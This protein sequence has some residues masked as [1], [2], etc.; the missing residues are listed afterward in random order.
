[1]AR[2][3]I[4]VSAIAEVTI[5]IVRDGKMLYQP[6]GFIAHEGVVSPSKA[7]DMM[8]DGWV[9]AILS[10]DLRELREVCDAAGI[11]SEYKEF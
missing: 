6:G 9:A 5:C 1:M 3:K 11:E 7:V 10:T 2:K 8:L 4:D